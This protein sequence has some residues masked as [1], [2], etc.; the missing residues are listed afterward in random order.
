MGLN[1]QAADYV[2]LYDPWWNAA[3]ENQ[4]IDRAHRLG[5]KG[6]LHAKRYLT[7]SSIEERIDEQKAA[8][9]RIV[10]DLVEQ[11][12]ELKELTTRDLIN[13]LEDL[14]DLPS[15]HVPLP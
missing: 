13:L 11:H 3:V 8:K 14:P 7:S 15:A 12:E 2:F 1:L 9:A 10:Q 5:R 4:A 6:V